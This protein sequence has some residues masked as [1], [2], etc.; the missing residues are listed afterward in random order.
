N[1]PCLI[2]IVPFLIS[3]VV[4]DHSMTINIK[5]TMIKVKKTARP[6]FIKKD[7]S[8]KLNTNNNKIKTM[9][10]LNSLIIDEIIF[11]GCMRKLSIIHFPLPLFLHIQQFVNVILMPLALEGQG[12]KRTSS[13]CQFQRYITCTF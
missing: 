7:T 9:E 13:L 3:Y 2:C 4:F 5:R 1:T 6:T 8:R 10:S 12:S 11:I